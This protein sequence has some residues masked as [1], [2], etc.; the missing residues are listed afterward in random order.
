M[1]RVVA[2]RRL[3]AFMLDTAFDGP[4]K[5]VTIIFGPSGAGKSATLATIAGTAR[6]GEAYVA[7]GTRVLSD[8][9]RRQFIPPPA[10][11][12]G[13]VDQQARLFPHLPVQAN[14][15]YGLRRAHGRA[16]ISF[17]AV[18]ETLG[19]GDLLGRRTAALSG[20]EAQRVA[21]G[22]ALLSQPDLLLLDEPLAALDESRKGDI[23]TFI[24]QLKAHFCLPMVYVTHSAAEALALGDHLVR[25]EAGRVVET[26][27]PRAILRQ[28]AAPVATYFATL[29]Q[30][31]DALS[32][33]TLHLAAQTLCLPGMRLEAGDRIEI[34]ISASTSAEPNL[35]G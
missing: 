12:I 32:Q 15:C 25:L 19:L 7:L 6:G 1:L 5:G 17:A 9:A 27:A 14:L 35:P 11:R 4:A 8:S 30:G 22:R 28:H 13:W 26:G 21:L 2:R 3:G 16:D 29:A 24:Q 20:G 31:G 23:L 34:V 18:V 33:S 10:R